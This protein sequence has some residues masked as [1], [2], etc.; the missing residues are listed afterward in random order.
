MNQKAVRY[1]IPVDVEVTA[2]SFEFQVTDPA[3]NT[4]LAEVYAFLW[5][6]FA[7]NDVKY[8]SKQ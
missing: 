1:V 5:I 6:T 2:D 4:M 3:G 8:I 7:E